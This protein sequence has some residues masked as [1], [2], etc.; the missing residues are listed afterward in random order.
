MFEYVLTVLVL[1]EHRGHASVVD[2]ELLVGDIS[3]YNRTLAFA[4]REDD[5]ARGVDL[6]RLVENLMAP[7]DN[8]PAP[9]TATRVVVQKSADRG[10]RRVI[11]VLVVTGIMAVVLCVA[12][13]FMVFLSIVRRK[14]SGNDPGRTAPARS[15]DPV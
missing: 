9:V 1:C 8:V 4:L 7:W 3:F 5:E 13:A 10:R 15:C 6:L 12:L 14:M 11:S 2:H